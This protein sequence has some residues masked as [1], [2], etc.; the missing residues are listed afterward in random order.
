MKQAGKPDHAPK[1]SPQ[2][3][4][5][6]K[7]T[8]EK[9][10]RQLLHKKSSP[11]P[12]F[13]YKTLKFTLGLHAEATTSFLPCHILRLHQPPRL[14]ESWKTAIKYERRLQD[15]N[16]IEEAFECAYRLLISQPTNS[17][18]RRATQ[19]KRQT[20]KAGRPQYLK[21]PASFL[22]CITN[23]DSGHTKRR[24]AG[25]PPARKVSRHTSAGR[26]R[27][28]TARRHAAKKESRPPR[29]TRPVRGTGSY[30]P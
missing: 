8:S 7:H 22:T 20:K 2:I 16:L 26:K 25:P 1:R 29:A 24:H 28:G 15:N 23:A 9:Q 11:T 12:A 4:P 14:S 17:D 5:Y 6:R 10:N 30:Y 19:H 21:N 3:R 13:H 18:R 27:T